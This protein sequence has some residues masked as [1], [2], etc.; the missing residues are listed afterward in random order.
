[1]SED[2]LRRSIDEVT[3]AKGKNLAAGQPKDHLSPADLER[4]ETHWNEAQKTHVAGCL[5]CQRGL[6]I[7]NEPG[8]A[9]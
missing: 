2:D 3:A 5:S 8:Q 1:M 6:K 7:L 9:E 4:G